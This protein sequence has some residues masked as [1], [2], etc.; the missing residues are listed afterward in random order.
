M[1][2]FRAAAEGKCGA[3]GTSNNDNNEGKAVEKKPTKAERKARDRRKKALGTI[4]ELVSRININDDNILTELYQP[5]AKL[6][7]ER[8]EMRELWGK[9]EKD[10]V[11]H[12][13]P[14]DC[15]PMDAPFRFEEQYAV[16]D[17]SGVGSDL[18]GKSP[19]PGSPVKLKEMA[20]QLVQCGRAYQQSNFALIPPPWMTNKPKSSRP[21]ETESLDRHTKP[22]NWSGWGASEN[23]FGLELQHPWAGAVVDGK[24]LIETRSYTLPPSLIGKKIMIVES[25]SGEAGISTLGNCVSLSGHEGARIKVIGWCIF[26]S[27][28]TYTTGKDFRAEEK[29]HLVTPD[30]GY[31]WKDGVTQKVYSWIIGNYHRYNESSSD[32]DLNF[33]GVRRF[34]SLFQLERKLVMNPSEERNTKR[35]NVEKKN[36]KSGKKKRKRY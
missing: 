26:S 21:I 13:M 36:K 35:T 27:V 8:G 20:R 19:L 31:G 17:P 6:L 25:T 28:K 11:F 10:H 30:S 24:K 5:F 12:E 1:D 32:V 9:R 16:H 4:Q 14:P 34:R 33:S 15:R 23:I 2:M 7:E 22:M 18:F 29:L 3:D